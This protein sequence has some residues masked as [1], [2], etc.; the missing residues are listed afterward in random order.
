MIDEQIAELN[1]LITGAMTP[2]QVAAIRLTE[3]PGFG[4]D[5]AEI[6][7]PDDLM[8]NMSAVVNDRESLPVPPR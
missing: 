3:V 4:I 5:P 1:S 6:Y 8:P 2:H 7:D